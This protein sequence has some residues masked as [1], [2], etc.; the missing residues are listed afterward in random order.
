MRLDKILNIVAK[1]FS[2]ILLVGMLFTLFTYFLGP[3]FVF[4]VLALSA[5]IIMTVVAWKGD[6]FGGT[7][8]IIAASILSLIIMSKALGVIYFLAPGG[9]FLVGSLFLV[10]YVYQGKALTSG[11]DDF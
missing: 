5:M 11:G 2:L 10:N 4:G 9:L 3:Y 1:T 7:F 6:P 8:Y